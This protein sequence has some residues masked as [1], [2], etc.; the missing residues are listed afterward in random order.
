MRIALQRLYVRTSLLLIAC[1]FLGLVLWLWQNFRYETLVDHYM[2]HGYCFMW[3]PHLVTLHVVSDACIGLSYFIIS[4]LLLVIVLKNRKLI[5]FPWMFA[6]F[7]AFIVACGTAHFIAIQVLWQP[8]YWFEGEVKL[9]TAA[10]SLTT[11]CLLP[12][13]MPRINQLLVDARATAQAEKQRE[14]AYTFTR[15]IIESST[16]AILVTDAAGLITNMNPAA[17]R[18]LRGTAR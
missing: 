13:I 15:S 12:T 10:V 1:G 16:F 17:E 11:A 7:G 8:Y 6:A 14:Q 5:P 4:A 9:F 18:L 3:N 2:P